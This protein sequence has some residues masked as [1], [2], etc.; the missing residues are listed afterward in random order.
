VQGLRFTR[1]TAGKKPTEAGHYDQKTHQIVMFDRAFGATDVVSVQ[2][3]VA[4]SYATRS[5][6]HEI[7]HAVDLRR[8]QQAYEDVDQATRAVDAASGKFTS[9]AQKKTYD[10]AV[11]A[12]TAAKSRLKAA[13]S[14]SGSK[15]VETSPKNYEDVI[16]TDVDK[17]AFRAAVK[18]DGKDVSKYGEEDWQESYAEAYSLFVTTPDQLRAIRPA[19]YDYFTKNLP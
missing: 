12:E 17:N 10:D 19:T 13:R 6:V 3:G 18:K 15:T 5:I 7:G 4:A 8:L 16:G 11:K 1:A 14:R 9:A 2:G